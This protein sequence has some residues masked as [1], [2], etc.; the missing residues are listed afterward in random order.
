MTTFNY[1]GTINKL[2]LVGWNKFPLDEFGNDVQVPFFAKCQ[3]IYFFDEPA[4]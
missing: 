4:H 3:A 1:D 2:A